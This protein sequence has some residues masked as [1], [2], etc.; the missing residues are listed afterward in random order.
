MKKINKYLITILSILSLNCATMTGNDTQIINFSS[1]E[2]LNV[3]YDNE[4]IGTTPFEYKLDKNMI[5]DKWTRAYLPLRFNKQEWNKELKILGKMS[6][7]GM[8]SGIVGVPT[9][10]IPLIIDSENGSY[11]DMPEN[12]HIEIRLKDVTNE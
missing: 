2:E 5:F 10:F 6:T 8:I 1:N 7:G 12:I 9:L 4:L 3:Y 11:W